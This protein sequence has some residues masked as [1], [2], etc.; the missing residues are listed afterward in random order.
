[1]CG[2]IFLFSQM[3][4]SLALLWFTVLPSATGLHV[5]G[6]CVLFSSLLWTVILKS[7]FCRFY[8]CFSYLLVVLSILLL[9][10]VTCSTLRCRLRLGIYE[11]YT[12]FWDLVLKWSISVY[13]VSSTE[14]EAQDLCISEKHCIPELHLL[15]HYILYIT[16]WNAILIYF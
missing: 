3:V 16:F 7:L 14:V 1:M 13:L 11:A 10:C 9:F 6:P 5:S 4:E 2:L 15:P 12:I 8:G